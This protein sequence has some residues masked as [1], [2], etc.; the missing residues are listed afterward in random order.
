MSAPATLIG[1]RKLAGGGELG[2]LFADDPH[3]FAV[4]LVGSQGE[5]FVADRRTHAASCCCLLESCSDRLRIAHPAGA[6]DIKDCRRSV[7]EPDVKGARD[8]LTE[9]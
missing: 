2:H 8:T 9:A 6:H 1:G 3:L 5:D 4:V 7:I